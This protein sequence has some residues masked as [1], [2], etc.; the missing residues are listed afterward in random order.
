[1]VRHPRI[2]SLLP[3]AT[4]IVCALGL[5]DHLVGRS[6]ECDFPPDIS[7]LPV[8]T[9]PRFEAEGSSGEIDGRVRSLASQALSLY[10]IR[11]DI[12]SHLHPDVIVTQTQCD[13]CAVAFD[14]VVEAAE[15]VVDGEVEIVALSATSFQGILDDI[16]NVA[17]ATGCDS[18]GAV[19]IG[20]LRSRATTIAERARKTSPRP[21]VLCLEWIDPLMAGGNWIPELVEMAGGTPLLS[22]AGEHSPWIDWPAL[23]A[24]DPDTIV[25][26]PCGFSMAKA[27]AEMRSVTDLDQ[28]RTLRAVREGR[29][30]VTDANQ[31]FNRPGPR[32]VESL[33]ILAEIL[34]PD[35]FSFGHAGKGWER[36]V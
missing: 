4:E 13:V 15:R 11:E 8:C 5:R 2:V 32:I 3:S 27:R 6:H 16:R 25:V 21:S 22:R 20:S 31:Y 7:R 23:A 9:A 24:A 34:H 30:H 33:E 28:W 29:V 19:V 26:M 14:D 35:A 17:R 10:E 12:L 36:F 18:S 1:M